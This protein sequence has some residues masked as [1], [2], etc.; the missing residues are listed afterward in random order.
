MKVILNEIWPFSTAHSTL[1]TAQTESA[2]KTLMIKK[3][4]YHQITE[5]EI[6][7]QAFSI[8]SVL[9]HT[10]KSMMGDRERLTPLNRAD[11]K[12]LCALISSHQN[13]SACS[14]P[15]AFALNTV[16][17]C[18][19]TSSMHLV[20]SCWKRWRNGPTR[21]YTYNS[22]NSV[23]TMGFR[24]SD[25]NLSHTNTR[26]IHKPSVNC[27]HYI[28]TKTQR[29]WKLKTCYIENISTDKI[30]GSGVSWSSG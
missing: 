8:C 16:C 24:T 12:N 7:M 15:W 27:L 11:G 4:F 30:R 13:I 21:W 1:N 10:L 2:F 14:V 6:E 23:F 29:Q 28:S 22:W 25:R 26:H 17:V 5:R 3:T 19:C 18:V 9:L 20:L